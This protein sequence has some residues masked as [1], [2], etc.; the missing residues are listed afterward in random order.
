MYG[1]RKRSK[2]KRERR[3]KRSAGDNPG[4]CPTLENRGDSVR[5]EKEKTEGEGGVL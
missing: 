3:K 4:D 2:R 1:G 5:L